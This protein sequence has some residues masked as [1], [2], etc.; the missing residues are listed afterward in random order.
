MLLYDWLRYRTVS[1]I[2]FQRRQVFYGITTFRRFSRDFLFMTPVQ[3]FPYRPPVISINMDVDVR[4][5][6]I[7]GTFLSRPLQ[8]NDQTLCMIFYTFFF[9]QNY[10][11]VPKLVLR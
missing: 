5:N 8:D 7:L 1:A 11:C 10:R 4:Y 9:F 3:I 2:S 6:S